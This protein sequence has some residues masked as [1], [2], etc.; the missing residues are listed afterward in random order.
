MIFR[1][2]RYRTLIGFLAGLFFSLLIAGIVYFYYLNNAYK[3]AEQEKVLIGKMAVEEYKKNNPTNLVYRIVKD[4]K[5]GEVLLDKDI[6][7]AELSTSLFPGDA[8]TDPSLAVGKVIRCS[9]KANTVLTESLYMK[10]R[11]IR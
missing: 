8:I 5:S 4:K 10:R 6:T 9:V 3:V 1:P 7:P 2:Q 11:I